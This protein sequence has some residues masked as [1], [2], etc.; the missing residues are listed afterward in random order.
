MS[1]INTSDSDTL[2]IIPDEI[3]VNETN[4]NSKLKFLFFSSFFIL[5][6]INNIG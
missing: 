2:K 1:E 6:I 4:L 3:E 5:G